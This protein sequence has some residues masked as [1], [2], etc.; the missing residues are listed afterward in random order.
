[1]LM[2]ASTAE[3]GVLLRPLGPRH[4]G[5][6]SRRG[7]GARTPLHPSVRG[8]KGCHT[9]PH[10]AGHFK[11]NVREGGQFKVAKFFAEKWNSSRSH[12]L[13]KPG[14]CTQ[15]SWSQGQHTLHHMTV[16]WG[17][18]TKEEERT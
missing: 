11:D 17:H 10:I 2:V 18:V 12:N 4:G 13:I 9:C 8:T 16:M 3:R 14:N 15:V 5:G 6:A 7:K 1:M